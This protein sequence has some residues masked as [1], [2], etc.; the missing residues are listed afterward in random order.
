VGIEPFAK[1]MSWDIKFPQITQV[2]RILA[3]LFPLRMLVVVTKSAL[4][5]VGFFKKL[6]FIIAIHAS[7][8]MLFAFLAASNLNNIVWVALLIAIYHGMVSYIFAAYSLNHYKISSKQTLY[9]AFKPWII[10]SIS[11]IFA[12]WSSTYLENFFVSYFNTQ[13]SFINLIFSMI[14]I[15]IIF[16]IAIIQIPKSREFFKYFMRSIRTL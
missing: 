5:A 4:M 10:C 9:S 15:F 12:I 16:C 1:L 14:F 2:V 13:P 7:G 6:A 8:M 3:F 11:G